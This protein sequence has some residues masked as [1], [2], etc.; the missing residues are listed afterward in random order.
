[1]RA[2]N[3][4]EKWFCASFIDGFP[5]RFNLLFNRSDFIFKIFWFVE[6]FHLTSLAFSINFSLGSLVSLNCIGSVYINPGSHI[7]CY[8]L[9][10]LCRGCEHLFPPFGGSRD[11]CI[12]QRFFGMIFLGNIFY[13]SSLLLENALHESLCL[14]RFSTRLHFVSVVRTP[15]LLRDRLVKCEIHIW[16]VS[17]V[18]GAS[19]NTTAKFTHFRRDRCS[20]KLHFLK[21][22]HFSKQSDNALR[23]ETDPV[24]RA[25]SW[26]IGWESVLRHPSEGGPL[27]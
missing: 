16:W 4:Q 8:R 3:L 22:Q 10:S 17:P 9:E 12:I 25:T 19:W 13:S 1:M 26:P 27:G 18:V 2:W 20:R 23:S 21:E 6:T 15:F 14:V 7:R 24:S 11:F 5:Q